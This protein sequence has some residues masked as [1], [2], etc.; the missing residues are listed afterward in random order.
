M[1][2]PVVTESLRGN[3]MT[4]LRDKDRRQLT[5]EIARNLFSSQGL[6]PP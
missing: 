6:I 2:H 4:L 5:G 3:I 1:I